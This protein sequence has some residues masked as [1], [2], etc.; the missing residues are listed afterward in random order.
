LA[1]IWWDF[2]KKSYQCSSYTGCLVS[3]YWA[4]A[5]LHTVLGAKFWAKKCNL[6][7]AK[8]RWDFSFYQEIISMFILYWVPLLYILGPAILHTRAKILMGFYQEIISTCCSTLHSKTQRLALGYFVQPWATF[9]LSW[10]TLGYLGLPWA[11]LG[12]L[13][14]PWATLG[15]L[16]LYLYWVSHQHC[17]STWTPILSYFGLPWPTLGF[18]VIPSATYEELLWATLSY[19]RRPL[20]YTFGVLGLPRA[21]LGILGRPWVTLGFRNTYTGCPINIVPLPEHLYWV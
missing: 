20:V 8:I 15:Y 19:I 9:G 21:I 10:A 13:G 17:P 11:T 7:L 14:L 2:T 16:G 12:Y 18:F 6:L 4:G 5:I 1:K 3:I